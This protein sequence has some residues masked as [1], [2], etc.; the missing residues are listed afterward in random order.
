MDVW[1][2]MWRTWVPTPA[3]VRRYTR[4]KLEARRL[5]RVK[6]A[7]RAVHPRPEEKIVVFVVGCQ[8]SGTTMTGKILGQLMEVDHFPETDRRAFR[9][10]RIRGP[11]VR[12][13]L[14]DASDAGCVVFKPIVDS[15]LLLD[16][17]ADH[18]G[19][20]ALWVY[21]H[22]A[23][24][25][26]SAVIRWGEH[27]W[28][29]IGDLAAGTGDWGWRQERISDDCRGVITELFSPDLN[30]WEASALFWYVRNR[31]YF[32]QGLDQHPDIMLIK[33]EA[34]VEHPAEE[35]ERICGFLGLEY[36]PEAVASVHARSIGKSRSRVEGAAVV[37]TCDEMLSRLDQAWEQSREG[38]RSAS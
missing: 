25:A 24:V 6:R 10:V 14:I 12:N 2:R 31:F 30:V 28:K 19:S 33:Y 18:P 21:R 5:A 11:E 20:K 3:R 35:F 38:D 1:T 9:R 8:R 17:M 4:R 37:R 29:V 13:R 32:D 34:L 23:D 22:Y 15:H 27:F 7:W 26:N 36:Q 16:L